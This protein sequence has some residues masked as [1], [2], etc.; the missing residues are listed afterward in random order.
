[1]KTFVVT[2]ASGYIGSH[3]CY[4]LRNAYPDCKIIGIDK[5]RK[6]KLNH[7]Y[8]DF[9]CHDLSKTNFNILDRIKTDCIFHFAALAIVP[10]GEAKPYT[11]YRNNLMSSVNLLEEAIFFGVK[12]FVFSSSCAVY[13]KPQNMPINEY[14]VEQPQS[15]YA[16]TKFM[17][18]EILKAAE[19]EH[20]IH[21]GILRYFNAAGRNAEANLFEE[22]EPETHLIPNLVKSDNIKI[23]GTDYPTEDGTAIRDYIHVVDLCRAHI[24]TYEY[25]EQNK[26][27]ILCNLGTG[28]G[29]SVL[30]VVRLVEDILEKKF[31]IEYLPK[32]KGDLP[33]LYSDVSRMK[34]DLQF[35]PEHDIV[36]IIK[37]MRN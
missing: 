33:E 16:E 31:E 5:V 24:K 28:K 23:Y 13:G 10:E 7:L 11:Y 34:N 36:S 30:Q 32:R 1:M 8:D 6:F 9:Y 12:N 25:M 22:H 2:G 3:M 21:A 27:G 15:V 17:F 35:L 20:G 19:K 18:E 29:H 14:E 37:S 4:E 26:K